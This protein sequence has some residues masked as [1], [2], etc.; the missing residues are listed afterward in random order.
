[1][2]THKTEITVEKKLL[3]GSIFGV[4]KICVGG[5]SFLSANPMWIGGIWNAV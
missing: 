4:T 2:L 3:T 1:M 5:E